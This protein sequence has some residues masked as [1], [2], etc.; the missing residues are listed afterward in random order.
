[1]LILG[2]NKT[3]NWLLWQMIPAGRLFCSVVG[4]QVKDYS[5]IMSD[6]K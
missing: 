3:K 4:R 1:M 5:I 2:H 6:K